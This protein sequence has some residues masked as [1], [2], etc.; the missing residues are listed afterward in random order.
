MSKN[1]KEGQIFEHY[2]KGALYKIILV[3]EDVDTLDIYISYV[4]I[5]RNEDETV[6]NRSWT[7]TRSNFM[8]EVEVDGV[9]IPQY[10]R[11]E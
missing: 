3:S 9:K 5:P 7:R 4:Q 2:K 6:D 10:K 8:S 11:K 1:P